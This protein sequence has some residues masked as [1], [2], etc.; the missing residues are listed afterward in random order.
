VT[1]ALLFVVAMLMAPNSLQAKAPLTKAQIHAAA[2]ASSHWKLKLKKGKVIGLD[3]AGVT[4]KEREI[5]WSSTLEWPE[6]S[7]VRIQTDD[8]TFPNMNGGFLTKPRQVHEL[9]VTSIPSELKTLPIELNEFYRDHTVY[10]SFSLHYKKKSVIGVYKIFALTPKGSPEEDTTCIV[11]YEV[12]GHPIA[13][14]GCNQ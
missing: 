13:E 9:Q 12:V 11:S 4:L 2:F 6:S 8:P 7:L 3:C 14:E 10:A 1:K 5:N